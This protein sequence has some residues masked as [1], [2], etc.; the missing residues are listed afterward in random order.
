MVLKIVDVASH[1]GNYVF[2]THGEDGIIVKATEGTGYVNPNCDF[3][4]QQAI[5][6]NVPWGI[7]HYANGGDPKAEAQFFIK[8]IQ[9]YLNQANKPILF[10]DWEQGSNA[11]WGNTSWG[12]TFLDE[13]KRLTGH[14]GGV[15][16][17]ASATNQVA[18]LAKEAPLWIAGYPTMADVGWSPIEFGQLYSTGPWTTLTGWQFSSTPLDKS[19]FYLDAKAW[20]KIAGSTSTPTQTPTP[21]PTP[22]GWTTAGKNLETMAGDVQ[23]G[24]VGNGADRTAK[25]GKYATGVQAIVNERAKQITGDQSHQILKNETLAGKYGDG[26][27]RK[28][29]LGNYY[30]VVQSLINGGSAPAATYYTVQSGD[31]LS[32]I[33]AKYGTSVAN[34]Q[35]LNNIAN[36]NLIYAGQKL[37][38]K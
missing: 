20:A 38:V 15:Y 4:A 1:Q 28:H 14:Q 21:N 19:L 3:V 22:S 16:V 5:K 32:V 37:R 23:A 6:K 26:D 11:S 35:K 34:I 18:N 13:V 29:M 25:L 27:A 31:N 33:A 17:Q 7:Y 9:G 8:N 24:K 10:L 2:G 12:K 36:P 30:N